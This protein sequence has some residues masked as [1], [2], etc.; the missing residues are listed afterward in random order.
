MPH[1]ADR[2]SQICLA[3]LLADGNEQ[4]LSF[5]AISQHGAA[6]AQ[7]HIRLPAAPR[8]FLFIGFDNFSASMRSSPG[9]RQSQGGDI[10]T[11]LSVLV[12]IALGTG[13]VTPAMVSSLEPPVRAAPLSAAGA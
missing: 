3:I 13:T 7:I 11:G 1:S 5:F 12:V 8:H 4:G 2:Q 6:A 10:S 9:R